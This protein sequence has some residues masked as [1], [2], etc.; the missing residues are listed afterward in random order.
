MGN[1][2]GKQSADPFAQPGR[3]LGSAPPPQTGTS[4]VPKQVTTNVG[5]GVPER[6]LGG[7]SDATD[8]RTAAALAAE[9]RARATQ[10][11]GKIG[12]QLASQKQQTRTNTL[13]QASR[14]E[15]Q[16]RNADAAA[17]ARA[18]D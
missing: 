16:H 7:R 3:T 12:G 6:K 13:G 11:K 15:R 17:E 1:L 4:T 9:E 8:A 10:P 5:R 18:W 14:E 2:C